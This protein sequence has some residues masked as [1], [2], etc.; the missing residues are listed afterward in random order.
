MAITNFISNVWSETLYQ[1]L[2]KSYVA[3]KLCNREFEGEIKGEGD[4]VHICGIGPVTVF[5]YTKNANMPTAE[6]LTDSLRTLIINQAKGFNFCI[7]DVDLAQSKKSLMQAAMKEASNALADVADAYIYSLT[8]EKVGFVTN[9]AATSVNIIHTLAQ[10]RTKLL[11]NNVPNAARISLEVPPAIEQK[12]VLAKVLRS[13]DNH[14][15][16]GR[17]YIGSLLGFDVYVTNNITA[18]ANDSYRCVARTDRAIAFA[19]QINSVKAYEPELRHGDAVKGLH[20]YGAK[21]VYP[22]EM[23]YLNLTPA[24]ESTL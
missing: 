1:E 6:A 22:K 11:E 3:V 8:D 23:V 16:L 13:T 24:D 9:A 14:E 10:A 21:I 12:L 5:D 18:D 7:D 17:G 20:L 19:E 2:H 15:D 4:R